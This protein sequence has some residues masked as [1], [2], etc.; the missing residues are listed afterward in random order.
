MLQPTDAFAR[1]PKLSKKKNRPASKKAKGKAGKC[2]SEIQR[3]EADRVA[4]RDR[5]RQVM[6]S[7]ICTHSAV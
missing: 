5:A 3:I 4:R 2:L 1:K 7:K 6:C